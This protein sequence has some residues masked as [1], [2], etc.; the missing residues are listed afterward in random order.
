MCACNVLCFLRISVFAVPVRTLLGP[1]ASG[2]LVPHC[3]F[4]SR[5]YSQH[6]AN[7]LIPNYHLQ[8]TPPALTI[9]LTSIFRSV[10]DARQPRALDLQL[11]GGAGGVRL[12]FAR[13]E[14]A[15]AWGAGVAAEGRRRVEAEVGRAREAEVGRMREAEAARARE[16]ER[17]ASR[18]KEREREEPRRG[19]GAERERER[20]KDRERAERH[21]R[22]ESRGERRRSVQRGV[23]P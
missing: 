8:S 7:P 10:P 14:E 21:A 12:V 17:E 13:A 2:W 4:Y 6:T 22:R 23:G 20:E 5:I 18:A 3:P 1:A 9:P 11:V 15:A 19:G 16:R